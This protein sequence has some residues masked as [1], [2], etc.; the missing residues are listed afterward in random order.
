MRK[1][2]LN[3]RVNHWGILRL[4]GYFAVMCVGCG[5]RALSIRDGST[6]DANVPGVDAQITPAGDGSGADTSAAPCGAPGQPCCSAN[7][8]QS[9]GCCLSG[10]CV[11]EGS[12]CGTLGMCS[13]GACGGCG[14]QD[15]PCCGGLG[16]CTAPQT[17]CVAGVL[18]APQGDAGTFSCGACK[19]C[20]NEGEAC[21]P[22]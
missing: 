13:A 6:S 22:E 11:A 5:S 2:D 21:C 1:L 12:E 20:G 8:C 14:G 16:L 9:A 4:W 18:C 19:H 7:V 17:A 10:R 3:V 15:Q